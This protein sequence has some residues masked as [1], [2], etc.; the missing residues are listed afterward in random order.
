MLNAFDRKVLW[1]FYGSLLARGQCRK[2]YENEVYSSYKK[3]E[4]IENIRLRRLSVGHV[5]RM[6]DE[7][8]SK[9]ILKEYEEVRRPVGR[10]RGRWIDAFD[11]AAKNM[12]NARIGEVRK[13][14]EL[15]GGGGLKRLRTRLGSSA[16]RGEK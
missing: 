16:I 4:L 8:V 10:P 1:K 2:S 13:T 12:L 6:K 14:V 9:K 15:F 5:L 3:M 11:K 7:R